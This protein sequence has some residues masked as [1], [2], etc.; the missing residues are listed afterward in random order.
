MSLGAGTCPSERTT[1]SLVSISTQN[2]HE[3]INVSTL[4]GF[5]WMFFFLEGWFESAGG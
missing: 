5:S 4:G 3:R 1:L 2:L